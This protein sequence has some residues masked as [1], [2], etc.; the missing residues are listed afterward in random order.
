[1]K[2]YC[3]Q[4][5]GVQQKVSKDHSENQKQHWQ[6]IDND[7]NCTH[8]KYCLL[9]WCSQWWHCHKRNQTVGREWL[10][11]HKSLYHCKQ[12]LN[13]NKKTTNEFKVRLINCEE[14]VNT[15]FKNA[16]ITFSDSRLHALSLSQS[17][18]SQAGPEYPVLQ[19]HNPSCLSQVP[20]PLHSTKSCAVSPA[21]GS[22]TH[23]LPCWNI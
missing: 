22:S 17:R 9:L 4:L 21:V 2:Q 18:M 14:T 7:T 10:C 19:L 8:P 20:I 5:T 16:K 1:M 12:S 6:Y 13:K 15:L 11:W 23:A 3:V